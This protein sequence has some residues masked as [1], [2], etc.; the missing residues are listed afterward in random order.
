MVKGVRFL[1]RD[2]NE[3]FFY[4]PDPLGGEAAGSGHPGILECQNPIVL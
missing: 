3:N 4:H 1:S 2:D